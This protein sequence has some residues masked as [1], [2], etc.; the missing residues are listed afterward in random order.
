[1]QLHRTLEDP[2]RCRTTEGSFVVTMN[3]TG[4]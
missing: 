1:M 3:P 2:G 4:R